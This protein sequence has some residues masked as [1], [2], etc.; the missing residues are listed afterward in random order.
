M[1]GSTLQIIRINLENSEDETVIQLPTQ[2]SS[3]ANSSTTGAT[4]GNQ[5]LRR[6]YLDPTG[7][8][9]LICTTALDNYYFYAGWPS[10]AGT[11][12]VSRRIKA[13]LLNKLKGL[14]IDSVAWSPSNPISKTTTNLSTREVLLG[15]SDGRIFE[16]WFDGEVDGSRTFSR[17]AHDRFLRP[18]LLLQERQAIVGLKY[19]LWQREGHSRRRMAIIATTGTRILQYCSK[20]SPD[21][22]DDSP[23]EISH[24]VFK[25]TSPSTYLSLT[26]CCPL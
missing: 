14:S 2:G 16:T 7:Q 25:E 24:Q 4:S 19:Q 26:W 6:V 18:I 1:S 21:G 13:R 5:K 20:A 9:L 10:E 17:A 22:S 23:F 8:H 3:N 12:S 15:T 11:G